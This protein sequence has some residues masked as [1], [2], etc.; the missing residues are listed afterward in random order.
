MAGRTVLSIAHRLS[1]IKAAHSMAVLSEGR[2]VERGT[3]E[4]LT[5]SPGTL[6]SELVHRQLVK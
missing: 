5:A 2:I 3:F 1:T 4:Q 6:F